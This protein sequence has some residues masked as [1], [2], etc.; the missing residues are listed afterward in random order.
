MLRLW[1][2]TNLAH[3]PPT[4]VAEIPVC[5]SGSRRNRTGHSFIVDIEVTR[6]HSSS[7][8]HPVS[9]VNVAGIPCE[10][11][12]HMPTCQN[13][14]TLAVGHPTTLRCN[15]RLSALVL[16]LSKAQALESVLVSAFGMEC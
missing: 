7:T 15:L 5:M 14:P 9:N 12:H 3:P 2:V 6:A 13:V 10:W 11:P 4:L 1:S 8:G 16:M